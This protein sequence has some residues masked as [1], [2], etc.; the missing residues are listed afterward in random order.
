MV[1]SPT[2]DGD[3]C[4]AYLLLTNKRTVQAEKISEKAA[5]FF[6]R[7]YFSYKFGYQTLMHIRDLI[8]VMEWLFINR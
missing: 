1:L 3:V 5:S 6:M 8:L 4:G 7:G 2:P